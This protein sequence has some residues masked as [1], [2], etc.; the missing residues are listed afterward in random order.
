[1]K[2]EDIALHVLRVKGRWQ[3][4]YYRYLAGRVGWALLTILFVIVLNFFLFRI[5]PG[6]PARAGIRDPRMTAEAV[7]AI[8]VRFGLDKPLINCFESLNPLRLG[9]CAVNPLQTQFFIYIGNLLRGE[10]G[11]SYHTNRPVA[12]ML[13]ER[14]WNT[15]LLIGAGQILAIVI[16]VGLGL[17]AA[18]KARTAVD[19]AALVGSLLAWSLPTFWLGIILVLLGSRH[20]GLPIGGKLTPGSHYANIWEQW[21]DIGR[22]LVLPTLTFTIVYLGEYMLIMRS[23]VLEVLSEDYILTAKAKGLRTYQILKDHA[24]RNTMLPMVTIIALNLGF[25]VGGAIQVETVFSWPGVGL[26]IFEAV[27]R[28]DYPMLSGAFLLLAVSVVFANLI[29]DLLYS[30]L[31]PRVKAG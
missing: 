24:L 23:T 17:V 25:T 15:V 19:Y 21:L 31:D 22:H 9:D 10:M 7:E 5:L 6:D 16:G 11:I 28:R 20:F 30:V 2:R 18:W 29:A 26:A 8:R 12:D 14:L 1:V 3:L 13:T 4:K 27:G